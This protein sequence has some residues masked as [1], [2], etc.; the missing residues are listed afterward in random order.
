MISRYSRLH[1][2]NEY[3]ATGDQV[4]ARR[5]AFRKAED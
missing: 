2:E 4:E 1:P 5:V 3:L